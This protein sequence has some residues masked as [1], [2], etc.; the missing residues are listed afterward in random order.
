M[1]TQ[2]RPA[3]PD[4]AANQRRRWTSLLFA[5]T[6]AATILVPFLF[7]K[8]TWFGEPLTDEQISQYL[9]EAGK[10]RHIQQAVVQIQ[11][12]IERGDASAARWYPQMAALKDSPVAELRVTL[13][14]A[15][16]ADNRSELF[17]QT[18][19]ELL[20]DS[21][22]LVRRNA[23]LSLVRFGDRSGREE[24]RKMLE[25]HLLRAPTSGRLRY[26]LPV[27]TAL[28]EGALLARLERPDGTTVE[29]RSPLPGKLLRHLA[30]EGASAAEGTAVALI[31]PGKEHVWEAL[32]ALLL[33][34][35]KDDLPLVEPFTRAG[36]DDYPETIRQQAVL[37]AAALRR[38]L[39]ENA[40]DTASPP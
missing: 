22:L 1:E 25:P 34:G 26:R 9:S 4:P 12:R 38:R 21:N 14:W 23:A 11:E 36:S 16:G 19:L 18:L 27:G 29:V 31:A 13:A 6:A 28:N 40:V 5:L 35:E 7:W 39:P 8:Q 32:R 17:R 3:P 24:I 15:L 30:P 37:T 10:P 2:T 20:R 33:I